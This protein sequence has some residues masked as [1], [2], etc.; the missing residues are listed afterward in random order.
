M[1]I[2]AQDVQMSMC[3]ALET[4]PERLE[5][6]ENVELV[7]LGKVTGFL[8]GWSIGWSLRV[9]GC[10]LFRDLPDGLH[11]GHDLTIAD[12]ALVS[13]HG[14]LEVEGTMTLFRNPNWDGVIPDDARIEGR[15]ELDHPILGVVSVGSLAHYR[16]LFRER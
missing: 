5:A 12:T 10:P 15:I 14:G 4:L 9:S 11:V 2:R 7:N 1:G 6:V 3:Q 8:S 13:L 16:R